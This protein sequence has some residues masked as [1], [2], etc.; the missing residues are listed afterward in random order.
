MGGGAS[1]K[2]GGAGIIVL[3]PDPAFTKDKGCPK[4]WAC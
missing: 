1:I 2:G 4:S 3:L